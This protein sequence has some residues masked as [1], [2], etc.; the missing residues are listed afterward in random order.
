MSLID[1]KPGNGGV[2]NYKG[3]MLCNRPFA[4]SVAGAQ[5]GDGSGGD[6]NSFSCGV[7]PQTLG[8][9]VSIANKE[10]HIRRPKK[11][12]AVSRHRK[13]LAD[14]QKTKERLEQ[15]YVEE[16]ERKR[17][18][19]EKFAEKERKLRQTV[20][21]VKHNFETTESQGKEADDEWK[22]DTVKGTNYSMDAKSGAKVK[23]QKPAWALTAETAQSKGL[24]EEDLVP[25]EDDLLA[26]VSGLDYDKYIADVEV[27]TMMDR[28]RRRIVELEKEIALDDKLDAES[29]VR[30]TKRQLL[31]QE[32]GDDDDCDEEEDDAGDETLRAAKEL[33]QKRLPG[34]DLRTVHSA[35]STAALVRASAKDRD[36]KVSNEPLIVKYEQTEGARLEVKND[37]SKLPYMHRNPSL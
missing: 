30:S 9:T 33:L 37:I 18:S 4:G 31:D 36:E 27:K 10:K 25:D 32:T 13:W 16:A 22:I 8:T 23:K 35:Q 28:V 2:G 17:E 6:K 24:D 12:N 11:E 34:I 14:L 21:E 19:Q 3:V 26:F 5:K 29:T 20:R 7:V 1:N 15:E